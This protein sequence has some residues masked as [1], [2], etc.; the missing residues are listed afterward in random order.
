M[1]VLSAQQEEA[2]LV[3]SWKKATLQGKVL[4]K[5]NNK[6]AHAIRQISFAQ[7]V[8]YTDP[9]FHSCGCNLSAAVKIWVWEGNKGSAQQ[10]YPV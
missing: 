7:I 10:R 8:S 1:Q 6:R 4:Y 5:V 3:K 9:N 2:L